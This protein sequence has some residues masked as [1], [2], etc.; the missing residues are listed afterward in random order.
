VEDDEQDQPQARAF[1]TLPEPRYSRSLERGL[2]ILACF[3]PERPVLG[4]AEV[5]D[6]LGMSRATTHRY[7][8]TLLAQG[9]LRRDARKYRLG[10]GT[11]DLGMTALG[12]MGL[13]NHARGDLQELARTTGQVAAMAVLD[14]GEILVLDA[15]THTRQVQAEAAGAARTGSRLP[16]YC[17]SM[18]K[19]LLAY[20]PTAVRTRLTAEMELVKRAPNTITSRATLL[21]QLDWVREEGLSVNNE[22]TLAGSCAIAAPIWDESGDAIAAVSVTAFGGALDAADLV[23]RYVA[24]LTLTSRRI[25]RRLGWQ[26][27]CP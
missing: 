12:A 9:Y 8:S 20:L 11:V 26:H 5:A 6:S 2:A 13:C 22:E 21:M 18:G 15:V 16:A 23:D 1:P 24:K 17:T 25:S 19:V 7:M 10:L 3:T 4:I 14:G 27:E